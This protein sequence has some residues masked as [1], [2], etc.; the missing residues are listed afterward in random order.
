MH[1]RVIITIE[2]NRDAFM[3]QQ[4]PRSALVEPA[5]DAAHVPHRRRARS[6]RSSGT[7][8]AC[9]ERARRAAGERLPAKSRR[10]A[11]VVARRRI[12]SPIYR[13][14][15]PWHV[16]CIAARQHGFAFT[17]APR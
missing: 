6:A 1:A 13:V 10:R 16:G 12:V 7:S 11:T 9:A 17:A 2:R 4:P 5:P 14:T 15:A 8:G 3:T